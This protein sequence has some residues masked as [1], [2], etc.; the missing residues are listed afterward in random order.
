MAELTQVV[1]HGDSFSDT[2]V[3]SSH[4]DDEHLIVPWGWVKGA[5]VSAK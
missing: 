1:T 5:V 3:G 4:G 2:D